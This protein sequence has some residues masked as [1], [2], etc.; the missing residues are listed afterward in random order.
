MAG[1]SFTWPSLGDAAAAA[2]AAAGEEV[3]E[4]KEAPGPEVMKGRPFRRPSYCTDAFSE[5][6]P[7]DAGSLVSLG[8][9]F[10]TSSAAAGED[11]DGGEVEE[12]DSK[13]GGGDGMGGEGVSGSGEV[14]SSTPASSS[15]FHLITLDCWGVVSTY[16]V[17]ELSRRD[18]VDFALTD[19]GLRFG[20]RVRLLKA[21]D[22]LRYGRAAYN[23][24]PLVST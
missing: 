4:E 17:S 11:G 1:V 6:F 19:M 2:A 10:D 8:V 9:A 18:A 3:A 13:N 16:T 24:P 7:E 20:S 15:E 14:S 23:S 22:G 5:D 12:G 21:T